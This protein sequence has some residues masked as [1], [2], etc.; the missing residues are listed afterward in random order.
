MT[1]TDAGDGPKRSRSNVKSGNRPASSSASMTC[2]SSASQARS[3]D[4]LLRTQA[5]I[6]NFMVPTDVVD[7]SGVSTKITDWGL[8]DIQAD[9]LWSMDGAHDGVIFG[10]MDVGFGKHEDLVFLGLSDSAPVEDHGT[11]V[12][13]IACGS[14]LNPRG[15]RGV[16]PSCFVRAQYGDVFF[17]ST[18]GG[19]VTNLMVLFSQILG[20][21]STFVDSYDDVSTF[22]IS[23]GY[24]WVANFGIN[25]DAPDSKSWRALVEMQGPLV[26]TLLQNA[27]KK[28]KI[29]FS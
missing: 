20:S 3:C 28:G 18:Q 9:Q 19:E 25:P 15:V 29:I 11:H 13:G 2:A 7:G 14:H 21:L 24:N 5:K 1:G 16:L 27:E 26:V 22:N 23:L 6:T 4:V 10:V 17:K 8:K 12:S